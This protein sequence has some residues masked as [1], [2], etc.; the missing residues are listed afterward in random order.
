MAVG[1][2]A[3]QAGE[4][5][6]ERPASAFQCFQYG[7]V[8]KVASPGSAAT[9]S[10][11]EMPCMPSVAGSRQIALEP[12][13]AA[14]CAT[15]SRRK[16]TTD[17]SRNA[18]TSGVSSPGT[19][20]PKRSAHRSQRHVQRAASSIPTCAGTIQAGSSQKTESTPHSSTQS[21]HSLQK[22]R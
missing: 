21:A 9:S 15:I 20:P 14:T 6:D 8:T 16:S 5:A 22:S 3:Q 13:R 17:A 18:C 1:R 11:S 10:Q 19:G 2:L 4:A 12:P 7:S